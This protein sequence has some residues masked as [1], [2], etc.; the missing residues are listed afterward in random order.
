LRLD[1]ILRVEIGAEDA[2]KA[3]LQAEEIAN[4]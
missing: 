2:A 3:R 1:Q 4:A